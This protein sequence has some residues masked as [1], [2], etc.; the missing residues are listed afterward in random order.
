MEKLN[1]RLEVQ[2]HL[3]PG[4]DIEVSAISLEMAVDTVCIQGK[5]YKGENNLFQFN[6]HPPC[7]KTG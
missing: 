2:V 3:R 6:K 7:A 5:A 4:M 1:G